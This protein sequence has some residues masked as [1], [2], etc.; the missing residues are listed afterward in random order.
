M[1]ND[2]HDSWLK[3]TTT[4]PEFSPSLELWLGLGELS[5]NNLTSG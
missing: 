3:K 5:P 1:V 4:E 2:G